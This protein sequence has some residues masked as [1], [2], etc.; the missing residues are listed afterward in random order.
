MPYSDA[1]LYFDGSGASSGPLT[2]TPN[3]LTG[4]SQSGTTL[5]YTVATGQVTVGSVITLAGGGYTTKN[6]T[7]LAILTGNGLTGTA[8]V[9]VSQ[10]V[11]TTTATSFPAT[12]GDPIGAAGTVYSQLELDFGAPNTGAAYPW[13]PQFPSS[14]EKGYTFPPENP[15]SG[16]TDFGVHIIIMAPY[17]NANSFTGLTVDVCSDPTASATTVIATRILLLAKLQ[18]AGAKYFIPV[19]GGSV[20][21]FLRLHYTVGTGNPTTGTIVAYWGPRL[22]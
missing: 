18:I 15:G 7:V 8:T 14:V 12:I 21:E 5:T 13:L 11:T 19:P 10:T 9:N 16:G 20:L 1:L 3:A 2:S 6:V 17:N 22:S 4:V